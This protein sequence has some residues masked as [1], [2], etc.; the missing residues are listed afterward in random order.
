MTRRT[1]SQLMP[2]LTSTTSPMTSSGWILSTQMGS[3]TSLGTHT[4][5]QTP[6]KCCR[7]SWTR[8]VRYRW[9]KS[10]SQSWE[11]LVSWVS[12]QSVILH[13]CFFLFFRW[14][15]LWTLILKWT[16]TTKS[17]MKSALGVSMSRIKMVETMRAGAGLVREWKL[18]IS[19]QEIYSKSTFKMYYMQT[20]YFSQDSFSLFLLG[21]DDVRQ[22]VPVIQ[23]SLV[24]TW[25]PGGPACLPTISMRWGEKWVTN[26]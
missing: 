18:L 16:A 19:P 13:F 3:A 12:G 9:Q 7:V 5:L 10:S 23:T 17:T 24:Q 1:W 11:A 25:G 20:R 8:S 14:W 21:I 4:S 26:L 15:L 2:A 22:E 6:R